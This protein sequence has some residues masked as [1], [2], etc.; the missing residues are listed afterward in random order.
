MQVLGEGRVVPGLAL[1]ARSVM[2]QGREEQA[3][4]ERVSTGLEPEIRVPQLWQDL[5]SALILVKSQPEQLN[6]IAKRS[7]QKLITLRPEAS[8]G[9][10]IVSHL[11][12]KEDT[13]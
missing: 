2:E 4:L 1:L 11:C 3:L 12:R 5:E 9:S 6:I 13:F 7:C 10:L 8:R